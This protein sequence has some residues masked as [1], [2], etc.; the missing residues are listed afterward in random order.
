M[1]PDR[2]FVNKVTEIAEGRRRAASAAKESSL[3]SLSEDELA[4]AGAAE[5]VGKNKLKARAGLQVKLSKI[6]SNFS[7]QWFFNSRF[8]VDGC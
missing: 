5:S 6:Y 8:F 7:I 1:S 2:T 4:A 3:Q